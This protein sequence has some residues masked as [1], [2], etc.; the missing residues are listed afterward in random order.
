[1][2][3]CGNIKEGDTTTHKEKGLSQVFTGFLFGVLCSYISTRDGFKQDAK[4]T[5]SKRNVY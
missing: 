2:G 4:C 5:K 1:M 3:C